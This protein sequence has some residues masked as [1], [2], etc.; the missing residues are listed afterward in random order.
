MT[1]K[2]ASMKLSKRMDKL[3][4]YL[5]D[6]NGNSPQFT[7]FYPENVWYHSD[8]RSKVEDEYVLSVLD[9]IYTGH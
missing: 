3:T 1:Y 6:E 7:V 2:I 8:T 9:H 4:V 5:H